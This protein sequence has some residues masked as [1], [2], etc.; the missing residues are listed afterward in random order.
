MGKPFPNVNQGYVRMHA[1]IM[2]IQSEGFHNKLANYRFQ[3]YSYTTA[4]ISQFAVHSVF[5]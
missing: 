4:A 3:L 2:V 5:Y 1:H